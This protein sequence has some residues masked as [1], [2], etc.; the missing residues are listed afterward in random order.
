MKKTEITSQMKTFAVE[1][2]AKFIVIPLME[3]VAANRGMFFFLIMGN[4]HQTDVAFANSMG[5]SCDGAAAILADPTT[6]AAF[7]N[8]EASFDCA[9]EDRTKDKEFNEIYQKSLPET[10]DHYWASYSDFDF[11]HDGKDNFKPINLKYGYCKTKTESKPILFRYY[12]EYTLDKSSNFQ[13]IKSSNL[14]IFKSSNFK[15]YGNHFS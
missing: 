7:S 12:I 3:A 8:I 5:L 11:D 6:A 2:L 10:D 14:Q 15:S 9:I 13:I 1:I 4:E